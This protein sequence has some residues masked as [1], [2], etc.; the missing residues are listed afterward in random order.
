MSEPM[1]AARYRANLQDEVDSAFLYRTFAASEKQPQISEVFRRLAEVEERHG[2]F[3]GEK[4]REAAGKVP[5]LRPGW[6]A[7]VLAR[8]AKWLGVTPNTETHTRRT[9][10]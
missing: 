1:D 5:D 4:L 9:E 10:R 3:W 8:A 2:R 7:R 6:R